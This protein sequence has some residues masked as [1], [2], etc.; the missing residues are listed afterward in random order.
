VSRAPSLETQVKTL[1]R[2]L[3]RERERTCAAQRI[4]RG[5]ETTAEELSARLADATLTISTLRDAV[6]A[7]RETKR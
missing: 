6:N 5:W 3:N 4:A 7:L 1:R 2:D